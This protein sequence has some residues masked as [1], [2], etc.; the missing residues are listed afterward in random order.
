MAATKKKAKAKTEAKPTEAKP[1]EAANITSAQ[2]PAGAPVT[3]PAADPENTLA[4]FGV[5]TVYEYRNRGPA[6]TR[7][8]DEVVN[9]G[10]A[11]A[12]GREEHEQLRGRSEFELLRTRSAPIRRLPE[13][14]VTGFARPI[15]A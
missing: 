7:A 4:A 15:D 1:Q 5:E 2:A 14:A 10:H 8:G 3:V 13:A 12:A 9:T 6:Y 11:F